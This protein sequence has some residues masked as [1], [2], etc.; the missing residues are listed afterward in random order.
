MDHQYCSHLDE[1]HLDVMLEDDDMDSDDED[2][3]PFVRLHSQHF[4]QSS[5]DSGTEYSDESGEEM[6]TNEDFRISESPIQS[7]ED[8]DVKK[9]TIFA[10]ITELASLLIGDENIDKYIPKLKQ[11]IV[12]LSLSRAEKT[13]RH[14]DPDWVGFRKDPDVETKDDY[15]GGVIMKGRA[16]NWLK[17]AKGKLKKC[18]GFS[19]DILREFEILGQMLGKIALKVVLR[20]QL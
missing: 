6:D 3:I 4:D 14:A 7:E 13:D 10:K 11:L 2:S 17:L 8:S 16:V 18:R 19:N 9:Q 20:L 15:T 12:M 5:D 1:E